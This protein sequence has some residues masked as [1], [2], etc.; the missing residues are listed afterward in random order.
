MQSTVVDGPSPFTIGLAKHG[1]GMVFLNGGGAFHWVTPRSISVPV[2]AS[3]ASFYGVVLRVIDRPSQIRYGRLTIDGKKETGLFTLGEGSVI[4]P[5]IALKDDVSVIAFANKRD[6]G[7]WEIQVASAKGSEAPEKP[8]P[9]EI[10]SG[11]E[12]DAQAPV[13]ERFSDS[14]LVLQWVADPERRLRALMLDWELEP[15]GKPLDVSKP[16]HVAQTSAL[17]VREG[18]LFSVYTEGAGVERSLWASAFDCN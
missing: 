4:D 6:E 14:H 8:V 17:A 18:K 16:G 9:L 1:I 2:V 11:G 15:V 3:S 7:R 5:A 12:G 13:L 10:P